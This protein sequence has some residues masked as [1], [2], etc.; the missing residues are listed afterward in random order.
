MLDYI[1]TQ[2]QGRVVWSQLPVDTFR[3]MGIQLHKIV[4]EMST[5]AEMDKRCKFILNTYYVI[6]GKT[7]GQQSNEKWHYNECPEFLQAMYKLYRLF[8]SMRQIPQLPLF[9]HTLENPL[10]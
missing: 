9:G 8:N 10:Y 1:F 3:N 7:R 5:S 2:H 6:V 4:D